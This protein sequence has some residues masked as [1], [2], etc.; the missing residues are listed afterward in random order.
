VVRGS[1]DLERISRSVE[2][3]RRN[4]VECRRRQLFIVK[5]LRTLANVPLLVIVLLVDEVDE[6]DGNQTMASHTHL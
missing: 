5:G 4:A 2:W 3:M 1:G 6:V